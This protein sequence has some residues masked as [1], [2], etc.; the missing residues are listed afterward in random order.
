VGLS[1]AIAILTVTLKLI[2]PGIGY[3]V[4][5]VSQ[6]GSLACTN[7]YYANSGIFCKQSLSVFRHGFISLDVVKLIHP[8]YVLPHALTIAP[9]Y[10]LPHALTIAACNET[11][12]PSRFSCLPG[13]VKRPERMISIHATASWR[14]AV[15]HS[16]E[17]WRV[18]GLGGDKYD[19][20]VFPTPNAIS[21]GPESDFE[22]LKKEMHKLLPILR[23]DSD[24]REYFYVYLSE[25]RGRAIAQAGIQDQAKRS[26]IGA[27]RVD[28]VVSPNRARQITVPLSRNVV[29]NVAGGAGGGTKRVGLHQGPKVRKKNKRND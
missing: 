24:E 19:A 11:N 23:F 26:M 7:P 21:T 2:C 10:V 8:L 5:Y 28:E 20:V 3:D 17:A 22:R 18:R 27:S 29:R 9:L 12:V 14:W 13:T 4:V 6:C 16:S 1:W 15:E 25:L